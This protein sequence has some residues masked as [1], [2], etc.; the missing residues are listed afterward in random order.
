MLKITQLHCK[1][2]KTKIEDAEN[3][4]FKDNSF[5]AVICLCAI[6]HY[7]NPEKALSEFN[8][9]LKKG[10]ILVLDFDNKYSFRRVVKQVINSITN[11]KNPQ[12]FDIYKPYSKKESIAMVKKSGFKIRKI[13]CLGTISPIQIHTKSKKSVTILPSGISKINH[14]MCLD[15]IPIINKLATYHLYVLEK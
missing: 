9:I 2:C 6:V 7:P 13:R 8:R 12:G 10:G 11:N 14:Y 5:D 1:G 15:H 3:I 4:S